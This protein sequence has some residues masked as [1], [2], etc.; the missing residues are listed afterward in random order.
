VPDSWNRYTYVLNNPLALVDPDGLDWGVS[1][2]DDKK[3]HHT[4][5]HWFSGKIGAYDGHSYS[6][7]NFGKSGSLDVPT[8]NG[9]IV[10]IQNQGLKR[11]VIY[12]GPGGDGPASGQGSPL[13]A[14]AGLVDGAIPFGK[15]IR[16]AAFGKMGV[17]TSSSEY[18]NAATISAGV[19]IG[20]SLLDGAGEV[21]I[22]GCLVESAAPTRIYSA[23]VLLRS[24]EESG[25]M[26]N[27]PESFN[28]QIF[29]GSR[30]VTGNFFKVDK[31]ALSND[32]ILYRAPGSINGRA[33]T[34]EIGVRPSVSGRTEV[35]MHR[36]FR[37]D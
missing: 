27:F 6:A 18:E 11:Q 15:Q 8:D 4:N 25:P 22:A 17:D 28:G 1:E 16:E 31:Q 13:N 19:V 23:R 5:Y 20:V 32:S 24:A 26:H 9:Q 14:S 30:T 2:W 29:Q 37:P 21:R 36:F 35:I 34:F 3:G 10:R 12:S 33:G 7:V